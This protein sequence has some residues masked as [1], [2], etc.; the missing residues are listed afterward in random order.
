MP[1][2]DH[3]DRRFQA[4]AMRNAVNGPVQGTSA[5]ITKMAMALCYIHCKKKGWLTKDG[6]TGK[7]DLLITMHDELVFE[8]DGDILE[9]AIAELGFIMASNTIILNKRWPI[10][11]T[12][13]VEIGRDWTVPW[14]LYKL[15]QKGVF[16]QELAPFFGGV[17]AEEVAE[18]VAEDS[19]PPP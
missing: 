2:I 15:Q 18:E 5:D 7:V 12:I 13:D 6:S 9:Q 8:M 14:D 10:P 17:V 19:D 16:P 11:L 4:K 3:E 1:D